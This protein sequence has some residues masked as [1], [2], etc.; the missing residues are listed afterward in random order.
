VTRGG[1]CFQK[2]IASKG[3]VFILGF[4]TIKQTTVCNTDYLNQE[5]EVQNPLTAFNNLFR[6][7]FRIGLPSRFIMQ[8]HMHRGT[9]DSSVSIVN[10]LQDA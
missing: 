8:D 1:Y 2:G 5:A 7:T 9:Q 4:K 10:G 3:K 6:G